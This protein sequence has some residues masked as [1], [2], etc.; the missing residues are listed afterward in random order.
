MCLV[1]QEEQGHSSAPEECRKIDSA[2]LSVPCL[3]DS[4]LPT[5]IKIRFF[6]KSKEGV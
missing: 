1:T 5:T 3:Q 2:Q 4:S 6:F